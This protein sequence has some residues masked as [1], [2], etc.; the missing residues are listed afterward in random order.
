[1]Y[2]GFPFVKVVPEDLA[3]AFLDVIVRLYIKVFKYIKSMRFKTNHI[4]VIL[5]VEKQLRRKNK[6]LYICN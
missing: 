4:L 5:S 3:V 6:V 2:T 1:M